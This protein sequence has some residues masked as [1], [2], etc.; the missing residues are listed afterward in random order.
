MKRDCLL[1]SENTDRKEVLPTLQFPI[2]E[3]ILCG[4]WGILLCAGA[5][6]QYILTR[7]EIFPPK[8]TRGRGSYRSR[9]LSW[10]R[11][12]RGVTERLFDERTP[13]LPNENIERRYDVNN[14]ATQERR[15]RVNGRVV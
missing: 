2:V 7:K 8:P 1:P 13:L 14:Q 9:V 3:F 11:R 5:V 12:R 10:Y 15:A 6:C 4:V